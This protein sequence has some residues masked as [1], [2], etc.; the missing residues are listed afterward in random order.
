MF[1]SREKIAA[2]YMG[3]N[4]EEKDGRV[5]V[6]GPYP[7]IKDY[8]SKLKSLKFRY[9]GG[10]KSWTHPV[11]SKMT[12]KIL[13]E[14]LF[15]S[16]EEQASKSKVI[17][18]ESEE[19]KKL[20]HEFSKKRFNL[21]NPELKPNG[22]LITGQTYPLKEDFRDAGAEWFSSFKGY[23][24]SFENKS[25]SKVKRLLDK[26]EI[27]ESRYQDH[28]KDIIDF[29]KNLDISGA[30][31]S[32]SGNHLLIKFSIPIK[33]RLDSIFD[34]VRR[35]GNGF[36]VPLD[37]VTQRNLERFKEVLAEARQETLHKQE[38]TLRKKEEDIRLGIRVF[39][40]VSH[41]YKVGEVFELRDGSAWTIVEV[42]KSV[43]MEEEDAMSFGIMDMDRSGYV[44]YASAR[45]STD[46]EME[47]AG[48]LKTRK[49]RATAQ[50]INVARNALRDLIKK[51]GTIPTGNHRLANPFYKWGVHLM[52]VGGGE[53]FVQEGNSIWYVQNNGADG[54]NW[55]A[56]NV[57]TG[58]AG[59]I[60]WKT[61]VTPE[62]EPLIALLV[63]RKE[64]R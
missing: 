60:G 42:Q 34:F 50:Q 64:D 23:F 1:V 15:G 25:L 31:L 57:V 43:W 18:E 46:E 61:T 59:A 8:I 16:S 9:D 11:T 48:I 32:V 63:E 47:K 58:G 29:I 19:V 45:P 54:D 26:I 14:K 53:W 44:Y 40:R 51:H 21:F 3:L 37:K 2:L 49:E 10:T 55:A 24:I 62:M 36:A 5:I 22:I 4:I 7:V 28:K 30:D 6:S 17:Q 12:E 33:F 13:A 20:L 52:I 41:P 35:E 27:V 56:N 38:E 39:H